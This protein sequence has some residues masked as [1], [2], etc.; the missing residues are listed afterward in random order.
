[1]QTTCCQHLLNVPSMP[2]FQEDKDHCFTVMVMASGLPLLNNCVVHI[3]H[4]FYVWQ[5]VVKSKQD[6]LIN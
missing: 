3:I 4:K 1:M 2:I 5:R 6:E